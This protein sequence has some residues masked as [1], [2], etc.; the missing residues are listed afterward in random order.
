MTPSNTNDGFITIPSMM[1][2]KYIAPTAND[3]D[4]VKAYEQLRDSII[5]SLCIPAW[6]LDPDCE[7]LVYLFPLNKRGYVKCRGQRNIQK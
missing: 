1:D 4:Y 5:R 7:K 6:L 3:L 2:I